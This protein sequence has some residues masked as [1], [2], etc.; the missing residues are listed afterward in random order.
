M[1]TV[2]QELLAAAEAIQNGENRWGVVYNLSSQAWYKTTREKSGRDTS[3]AAMTLEELVIF[4]S[5]VGE[6]L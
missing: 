6:S 2:K 5:F 1:D 3:F 4:L